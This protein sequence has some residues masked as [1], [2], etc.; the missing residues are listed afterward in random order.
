MV[1]V[2]LRA[3]QLQSHR[4]PR[5]TERPFSNRQRPHPSR[6]SGSSGE[7]A[8]EGEVSR[9][10]QRPSGAG[11]G[12]GRSHDKCPTDYLLQDLADRKW[13]TPWTQSL[14]ITLPKKCNLKLCQ[15]YRTISLISHPSK[16]MLKILLNR[17]KPQAEKIIAEEQAGFRPGRS[18][19][20]QI[21]NLRILCEK[22]LQHQ[23]DLCHVFIDFKN[24]FERVWHAALWAT[25][26]HFNINVNLI[27]MIQ[28][29]Y[30]KATRGLVQNHRRSKTVCSPSPSSISS[31][32]N[33]D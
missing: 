15:N 24:A 21:F 29:L 3:V 23:Q 32:E 14:I 27:R 12:R 26:R 28:N 30:E 17:L 9:S 8:Q 1:R 16:V 13:P 22:Y 31:R 20:E 11:A 6:R 19:K 25:M 33:Y 10:G 18:T 2:L 5:S 4:R 7:V